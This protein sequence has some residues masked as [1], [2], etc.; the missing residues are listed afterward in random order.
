MENTLPTNPHSRLTVK[1]I[2]NEVLCHFYFEKGLLFTFYNM[3]RQPGKLVSVYL[4]ENR[5][6]VFNPFRYLLFGVATSTVILL[7]HPSFKNMITTIHNGSLEDYQVLEQQTNLPLWELM[8]RMQEIYLS[9]QNI[10]I[11]L[12]I[13]LVSWVTWLYFGK[14][15]YNYA[16]NMAINSFVFGT[17]YWISA[18]LG[19]LTYG[20]DSVIIMYMA[21]T[22]TFVAATYCYKMIFKNGI[23]KSFLGIVLGYIP[24]LLIGILSQ[25][26]I[27]I[28]L[29]LTF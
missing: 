16:E 20:T 22:L 5:K 28:V 4:D 14:K 1:E 26:L 27:F 15:K 13:P 11:I 9:Y 24:I 17:T 12:S 2:K 8:T 3:L 18:I 25:F 21:T 19:L 7:A 23:F 29:L 10:I 6:K